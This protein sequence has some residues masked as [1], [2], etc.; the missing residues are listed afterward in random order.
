MSRVA[1]QPE[2]ITRNEAISRL[3]EVLLSITDE[4]TCVCKAVTERNIFCRGFRRLDDKELR[5]RYWWIVRRRPDIT[6]EELEG[7]AND[8]Q[9][10]Q[11]EVREV[12]L[13]CDVQAKAQDTCRGWLD[14][15]NDDLA[16]FFAEL[17]GQQVRIS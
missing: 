1:A 13:A 8:W 6:R 16:R 4:E 10:A 17:T 3:R 5:E 12:P 11:Q 9:L 15:S 14:F 2:T 7:I